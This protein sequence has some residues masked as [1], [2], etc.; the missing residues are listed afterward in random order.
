M[1]NFVICFELRDQRR[2]YTRLRQVLNQ[3]AAAQVQEAVWFASIN[4]RAE[5]LKDALRTVIHAGDSVLVVRLQDNGPSDWA[6]FHEPGEG[7][8]WLE[9]HYR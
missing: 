7:L 9:T 6:A 5:Q 1:A 8:Q 3:M 2:D 4:G